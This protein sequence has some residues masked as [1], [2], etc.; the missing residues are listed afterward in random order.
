MVRNSG[1]FTGN[2]TVHTSNREQDMFN[3][4]EDEFL[5]IQGHF[6]GMPTNRAF[7][8]VQYLKG[9]TESG[10]NYIFVYFPTQDLTVNISV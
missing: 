3:F 5:G 9:F 4:P 2:P 1:H 10:K 6:S 8:I 7:E